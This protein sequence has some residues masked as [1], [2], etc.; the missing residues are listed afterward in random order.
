MI[1]FVPV[2]LSYNT[3]IKADMIELKTIKQLEFKDNTTIN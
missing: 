1:F 2:T 3:D